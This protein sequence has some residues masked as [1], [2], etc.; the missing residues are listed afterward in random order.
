MNSKR[1][2]LISIILVMI[3]AMCSIPQAAYALDQT[4][5]GN[6]AS[7]VTSAL[8]PVEDLEQTDTLEEDVIEDTSE[9][10][11]GPEVGTAESAA[12][13]LLGITGETA[14]TA[15]PMELFL[16]AVNYDLL[17][18]VTAEY[19]GSDQP[20]MEVAIRD[21][22]NFDI[23]R[24]GIYTIT[25]EATHQDLEEA[26]V[27]SRIVA[28]IDLF[29][30]VR[31]MNTESVDT[32]QELQSLITNVNNDAAETSL[33]V[34]ITQA[35]V[36]EYNTRLDILELPSIRQ[37]LIVIIDGN[38]SLLE[39]NGLVHFKIN[40]TDGHYILEKMTLQGGLDADNK[41]IGGIQAD[42]GNSI[43][44]LDGV[45]FENLSTQ[46]VYGHNKLN[47]RNCTFRNMSR[48]AVNG[49]NEVDI[50]ESHF[51]NINNP[52]QVHGSAIHFR[53]KLTIK[54][55]NIINCGGGNNS[56]GYTNGAIGS[57]TNSG[58]LTID[59]CNFTNNLGDRYGGAISL[60]QYAGTVSIKN[61]Y[62]K[63]NEVLAASNNGDGGA[64]GLFN[65][66][67]VA[68]V[69]IDNCTF[70]RNIARDDGGALFLESNS[71]T[72]DLV[73]VRVTNCTFYKNEAQ[74]FDDNGSG[75]AV[76]LSLKAYGY[77][78][79]NTFYGNIDKSQAG[80]LGAGA[81]IGNHSSV[82]ISPPVIKS[83]RVE[84]FNNLFV[85]N[86]G[87]PGRTLN[88]NIVV[89]GTPKGNIGLDNNAS[90]PPELTSENVAGVLDAPLGDYRTALVAGM[91]GSSYE[92]KLKTVMI[93]PAHL[94]I[95]K[96]EANGG[97]EL[98]ATAPS[99]DARGKAKSTVKCDAGAVEITW[100][101]FNANGGAFNDLEVPVL[102]SS[103]YKGTNPSEYYLI[104]DVGQDVTV[105]DSSKLIN[106]VFYFK[107][108]NT[109][110]DGSGTAISIGSTLLAKEQ[111]IYAI[112]TSTPPPQTT[113]TVT[114][115]S[116]QGTAVA[117]ITNIP[118]GSTILQ[119]AAPT[120]SGYT[121]A[122]WYKD[123]GTFV[124]AWNFTSDQV[125]TNI[126]LYAK[127][128]SSG[129]SG[130]GGG[131]TTTYTVT[132]DSKGGTSVNS[133]SGISP[134]SK[135]SAPKSPT[136]DGYEFS[137]WYTDDN[138]FA[139]SWNFDIK[140]VNSNITLYAKWIPLKDHEKE[141]YTV[142]FESNGGSRVPSITGIESGSKIVRPK[143]PIRE[144]Y[145]FDGW[146]L[147][148]QLFKEPWIFERNTVTA[149]EIL[150]A[151][152]IELD[153]PVDPSGETS[154]PNKPGKPVK[155]P[156]TDH[157]SPS[158]GPVKGQPSTG[159]QMVKYYIVGTLLVAS[160]L[161]LIIFWRKR[162]KDSEE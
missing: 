74:N 91:S 72:D 117:P 8:D 150:F 52:S 22:G 21:Q 48:L 159:E 28:V 103:F 42:A 1:S 45:T 30:S 107:E 93:V 41:G 98:V 7:G 105:I 154:N 78:E 25:Y 142:I 126:T 81:A 86:I 144:G 12:E 108:W 46:A 37:D 156:V 140:Q 18:G 53:N 111:T 80:K 34:R 84:L 61:S 66:G 136:K 87:K 151:K 92:T 27:F 82:Q 19:M 57:L 149:D 60:Y 125:N 138:I 16:G 128:T 76:Q 68:N 162:D 129:G 63:G 39:G 161:V 69:V 2:K 157:K 5:L 113:Y 36:D 95:A 3:L 104:E 70:E 88:V 141:K 139:D 31:L 147:D 148:D 55:S 49:G 64:L 50:Y 152:W 29:V 110:A 96:A 97:G 94:G 14:Y 121:F 35:F 79:N 158:S 102:G 122:G 153:V 26:L 115:V 17:D 51:E 73:K 4:Q 116:N 114:F 71:T 58:D 90:I 20:L 123:D 119:P 24:I 9:M 10:L 54:K 146:Y 134:G 13:P 40:N 44:T 15:E 101:K 43:L 83:P 133:I 65:N 77:F 47:I 23:N 145:R 131:G 132:F 32:I 89:S 137:G 120:R 33:T 62:F 106:G 118:A 99:L 59:Q 143:D 6:D 112:W 38:N 75:G 11:A 56:G 135:I 127:W 67:Q 109:K 100:V 155:P 124:N 130:G 160:G 85:G